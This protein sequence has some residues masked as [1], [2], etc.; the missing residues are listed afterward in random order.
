MGSRTAALRSGLVYFGTQDEVRLGDRIRMR[1]FLVLKLEGV[2]CYLP[3]V[4]AKHRDMEY[5][6]LRH[7][8][9]ELRSG[10]V[11]Q[12]HWPA[13]RSE[14]PRGITLLERCAQFHP[15]TP[16]VQLDPTN[17]EWDTDGVDRGS[18]P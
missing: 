14:L 11:R 9:V 12:L 1:A 15:L 8:G 13:G 18:G 16:N 10:E 7:V 3:G 2:V 17:A 5:E 6:G 4:S